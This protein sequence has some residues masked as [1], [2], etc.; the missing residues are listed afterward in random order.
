MNTQQRK[1][2]DRTEQNT[3]N[4][5]QLGLSVS[6]VNNSVCFKP[7]GPTNHLIEVAEITNEKGTKLCL[8]FLRKG[9]QSEE[10][11]CETFDELENLN[12]LK[13]LELC[14]RMIFLHEAAKEELKK[15]ERNGQDRSTEENA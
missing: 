8:S 14:A 15:Q 11:K 4:I 10:E 9:L 3:F 5:K 12:S 2:K 6:K 7:S 13:I 1:E